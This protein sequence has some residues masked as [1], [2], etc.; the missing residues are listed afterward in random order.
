MTD[1]NTGDDFVDGRRGNAAEVNHRFDSIETF[2][3][4]TGVPKLQADVATGAGTFAG[5]PASTAVTAGYLYFASDVGGG[6]LYRSDGSAWVQVGTSISSATVG[7]GSITTEKLVDGAVTADK[8]A[9][10]ATPSI[11]TADSVPLHLLGGDRGAVVSSLGRREYSRGD[12][13]QHGGRRNLMRE[14]DDMSSVYYTRSTTVPLTLESETMEVDGITLRRVTGAG[15]NAAL[16]SRLGIVGG[17]NDMF[18]AGEK[19]LM[20]CY[21]VSKYEEQF[22]SMRGPRNTTNA[23]GARLV[24]HRPRRIWA[25]R[26]A[27]TT[28]LFDSNPSG[29]APTTAWGAGTSDHPWWFHQGSAEGGVLDMFVGGFQIEQLPDNT[30]VDGIAMIGDSTM[31]GTSGKVDGGLS[32]EVSRYLEALLNVN[33]YNRAQGG[34]ATAT[35]LARWATDMTPIAHRCKY[36]IIQGG[37]N[38][39]ASSVAN[40]TIQSNLQDMADA[41]IADDMIPVF[42]TITPNELNDSTMETNRQTMNAWIK[43][44]FEN[45]ID[46][47]AVIEDPY[48]PAVINRNADWDSDGTHYLQPAKRAVAARIAS[49]GGWDFYQPTVYQPIGATDP[50]AATAGFFGTTPIVKPTVSGSKASGAALTSLLT[51]MAALG[52]IVDSSSA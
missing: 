11:V 30:Y 24:G 48:N 1:L 5:R 23:H 16:Q 44:T 26:H 12:V 29:S 39:I 6:T 15:N 19:Y 25:L 10:G 34:D 32:R 50:T 41:A 2:V 21:A 36:A 8:L 27:N 13:I 3:N 22:I 40:A 28:E 7:D 38:D 43:T 14:S 33:V 31:A 18:V 52:L 45:V 9:D 46:I 49:W 51:Q 35:M 17:Y 4:S 20:S 37:I 47:A 42:L